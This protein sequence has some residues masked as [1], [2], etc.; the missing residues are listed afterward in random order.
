[1]KTLKDTESDVRA[2]KQ[3]YMGVSSTFD[4][5]CYLFSIIIH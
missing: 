1:M 3:L 2:I 4:T 5:C